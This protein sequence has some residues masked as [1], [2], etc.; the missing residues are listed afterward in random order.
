MNGKLRTIY[1]NVLNTEFGSRFIESCR[2]KTQK[3]Y[4]YINNQ[5]DVAGQ[6]ISVHNDS[7][8]SGIKNVFSTY[9]MTCVK[10]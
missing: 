5:D 1:T 3:C 7:F 4:D 8:S 6:K 2:V 9:R 10:S